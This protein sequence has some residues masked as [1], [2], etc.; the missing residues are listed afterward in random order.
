MT[1]YRL[2]TLVT[3]LV[4]VGMVIT[5]TAALTGTYVDATI[6]NTTNNTAGQAWYSAVQSD[7]DDLWFKSTTVGENGTIWASQGGDAG[8]EEDSPLLKTTI[9][10]LT[11]GEK[12]KI[13]VVYSA[14]ATWKVISGLCC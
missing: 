11:P 5:S 1:R 3:I 10:G 2:I 7:T 4:L 14:A 6:A 8:I 13:R 9:T 12:Y